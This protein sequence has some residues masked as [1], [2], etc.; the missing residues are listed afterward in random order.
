MGTPPQ[1]YDYEVYT[2]ETSLWEAA[3][4]GLAS[5]QGNLGLMYGEG[6]GLPQDYAKA[7]AY[8][9][10]AAEQDDLEAQVN[11]G[12]MYQ[13]GEGA[14]PNNVEAYKWFYLALQ[15]VITEDEKKTEI[16]D[17]IQWLEKRMKNEDIDLARK[18]ASSWNPFPP[19]K[20]RNS[21]NS[22]AK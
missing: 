2:L 6:L 3:D 14:T 15:H 9:E 21:C 5:A 7:F 8:F 11:L 22:L 16:R 19:I 4:Q 12:M 20:N 18:K 10:K 1:P 13:L 17:D